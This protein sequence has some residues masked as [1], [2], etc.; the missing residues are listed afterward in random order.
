MELLLSLMIFG[1]IIVTVMASVQSM[2]ASRIKSMNRIA[3]TDE[4]YFFSEQL[5]TIIKDGGTLDY[6]EY[7]N[8]QMVGTD[9]DENKTF[10]KKP[11][12]FGNYGKS[13]SFNP[14][15][16]SFSDG[17]KMYDCHSTQNERY[18]GEG[19]IISTLNTQ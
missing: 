9:L 4:L 15:S 1:I 17:W 6:E 16:D 19:C 7:W 12:G 2:T 14:N 3:L 10:Y 8:R 13:A 5:F 18:D 11:T